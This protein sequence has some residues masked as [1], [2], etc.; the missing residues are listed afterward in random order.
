MQRSQKKS[1]DSMLH[2][3]ARK[4]LHD[5]DTELPAITIVFL[6]SGNNDE[7]K[8]I[9]FVCGLP[10]ELYQ[11]NFAEFLAVYLREMLYIRDY[12]NS[13]KNFTE[14]PKLDSNEEKIKA[15]QVEKDLLIRIVEAND[16]ELDQQTITALK[17]IAQ[18]RQSEI[19]L[20]EWGLPIPK[21][22][23]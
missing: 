9:S 11:S 12:F 8:R 13:Q 7:T 10:D 3:K 22:P 17:E 2:T 19:K 6:A 5:Y 16:S 21:A 14:V 4:F 1:I 18:R 15:L 20:I 23:L